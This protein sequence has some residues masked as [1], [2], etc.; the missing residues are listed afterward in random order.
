VKINSESQL[1]EA[2]LVAL[3]LFVTNLDR[4]PVDSG[5]GLNLTQFALRVRQ[6]IEQS[7][8]GAVEAFEN[9][10]AAA[11]F[12]WTDDYSDSRW[13]EGSVRIFRIG[14]QFPRL[15]ASQIP[16]GVTEV[17]YTISLG[18]CDPFS[19]S[20]DEMEFQISGGAKYAD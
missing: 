2:D 13:L 18:E 7:S 11:G 17:K 14:P 10:L 3:F 20:A 15:A 12:R 6:A 5:D 8:P 19:V 9:L 4:A 16:T 1:D